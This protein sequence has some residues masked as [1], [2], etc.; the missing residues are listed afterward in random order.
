MANERRGKGSG[1]FDRKRDQTTQANEPPIDLNTITAEE[2]DCRGEEWGKKLAKGVKTNQIRNLYGA[3]QHIRVRASR[4]QPDTEDINRRLIFLKPKLAYAS[5]RQSALKP[6]RNLLV[7][8]I[9]SVVKKDNPNP[10]KA[11]EN[12]FFLMESIVA[13]HKFYGGKNS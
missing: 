8:A 6:L 11:R 9:D 4:P 7:Q 2:L 10:E 5:G 13:Y 12:F 3:V 1:G